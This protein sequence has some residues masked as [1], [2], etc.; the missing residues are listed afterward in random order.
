VAVVV[1]AALAPSLLGLAWI[2]SRSV[3]SPLRADMP[4]GPLV[5]PVGAATQGAP[6]SVELVVE[7]STPVQVRT[8]ISG[9]V[10]AVHARVGDEIHAGDPLVDVDDRP[11]AAFTGAAPLWRDL[12]VGAVGEDVDRLRGFLAEL[13]L[14][15]GSVPGRLTPATAEGIRQLNTSLGRGTADWVLHAVSLAWIGPD[16]L[17]VHEVTVR[18]GDVLSGDG[19][20]L[21]GPARPVAVWVEVPPGQVLRDVPHSLSVEGV[22]VD[23]DP[24]GGRLTDPAAVAAVAEALRGSDEGSGT[25]RPAEPEQVGTLPVSA[26]ITDA[27]GR[28]CVFDSASGPPMPVEVSGG[29]LSVAEVPSEWVGRPVLANPREVRQDLSC[30]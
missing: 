6:V 3:V 1:V 22:D 2:V 5:V 7:R 13:G 24:A 15:A 4:Q 25:V 14:D 10:T 17:P 27:G 8:T 29:S 19:T 12:A 30:G 20:L 16:P 26:I 28:T 23:Y 9:T 11:V 18:V 21:A